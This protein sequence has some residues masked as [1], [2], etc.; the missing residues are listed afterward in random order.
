MKA[1]TNSA[2]DW[3]GMW[4]G[5]WNSLGG[6]MQFLVWLVTLPVLGWITIPATVINMICGDQSCMG[7][8][9]W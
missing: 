8:P 3:V 4:T 6:I 7:H 5:M 2:T 1:D 9:S